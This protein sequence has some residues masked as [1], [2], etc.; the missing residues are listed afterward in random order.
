MDEADDSAGEALPVT[1]PGRFL[2]AV[3]QCL[4]DDFAPVPLLD[5]FKH[6]LAQAGE[7]RREWL[8]EVRALDRL[9][10]GPAALAYRTQDTVFW[11]LAIFATSLPPARRS[12]THT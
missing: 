3:A 10:R 9:L 11:W 6:P 8:D 7:T 5:L 4:A 2:L 1:P 12:H